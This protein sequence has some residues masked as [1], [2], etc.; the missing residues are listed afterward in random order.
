MQQIMTVVL[1]KEFWI[2]RY[3]KVK[4]NTNVLNVLAFFQWITYTIFA[5]IPGFF[6]AFIYMQNVFK[7]LMI[8]L[9]I[10]ENIHTDI[11]V[12]TIWG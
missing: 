8:V 1:Q 10:G 3:S 12:L 9:F 5:G 11:V 7:Y 6:I 4:P 2:Y